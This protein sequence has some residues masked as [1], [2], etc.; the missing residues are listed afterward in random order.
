MIQEGERLQKALARAGLG[1]RRAVEALIAEG[2]VAVNGRPAALGRRIDPRKDVVEVDGSRV[3]L[4]VGLRYLLMNK[5]VGVVTTASDPAGRPTVLDYVELDDRVWPVGR[6]DI[7]TSGALLLTNDGPLTHRL[8]HPR[9]GVAK[10]Y[11]A[12]VRGRISRRAL[13]ALASGIE[14]D[15]RTTAPARVRLL[16]MSAGSSL[17]EVNLVEGR[18]RQL[19]RMFEAVGH[20]VA[21]LART[22]V[23][24][25]ALGRLREGTVRR[26]RPD[27]VRALYKAAGV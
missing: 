19:R 22:G 3:P 4:D 6:L 16:E 24:P 2:R 1:S 12:E 8:T 18:N 27:E 23:G 13:R 9:F 14:L 5:P 17:V 10:T 25:V 7:D 20:P 21:A 15:G 26:L 11:V